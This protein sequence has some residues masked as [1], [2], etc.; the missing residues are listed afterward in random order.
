M[1]RI[2]TKNEEIGKKNVN[3]LQRILLEDIKSQ[4]KKKICE[5]KIVSRFQ[6]YCGSMEEKKY[7]PTIY[8]HLKSLEKCIRKVENY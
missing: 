3:Q 4:N 6:E 7:H 1:R 2:E 8:Q 5:M